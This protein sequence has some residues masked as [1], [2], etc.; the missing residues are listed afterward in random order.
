ML[1]DCHKLTAEHYVAEPVLVGHR[2]CRWPNITLDYSDYARVSKARKVL[3]AYHIHA[4]LSPNERLPDDIVVHRLKFHDAEKDRAILILT[5][6]K[7]L[8]D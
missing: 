6:Y 4:T 2:W 7:L 8:G 3:A 5:R 1:D